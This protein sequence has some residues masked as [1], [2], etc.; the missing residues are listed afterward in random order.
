[1][2]NNESTVVA[3]G[4]ES[5]TDTETVFDLRSTE[6]RAAFDEAIVQVVLDGKGSQL[7][8]ADVADTISASKSQISRALKRAIDNGAILATGKTRSRRYYAPAK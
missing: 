1:M 7:S 8:I 5:N 6:G 4:D 3:D 2:S